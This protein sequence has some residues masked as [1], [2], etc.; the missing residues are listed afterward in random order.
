MAPEILK[1][2]PQ[3]K[4]V[5]IWS[6]GILL[7][8]LFE[9]QSPFRGKNLIKIYQKV[10]MQKIVFS[11]QTNPELISLLLQVLCVKPSK[12][13][14]INQILNHPY[15]I[16]VKNKYF[17]NKEERKTHKTCFKLNVTKVQNGLSDEDID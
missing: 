5:D 14:D 6:L 4:K 16:K 15:I 3:S 10:M 2:K 12:R 11:T 8:E 9:G 7:Y 13:P 1:L 17:S